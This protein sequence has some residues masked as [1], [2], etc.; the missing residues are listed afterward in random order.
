MTTDNFLLSDTHHDES[1]H[2]QVKSILLQ[3]MDVVT[4]DLTP[5]SAPAFT[6]GAIDD[7]LFISRLGMPPCAERKAQPASPHTATSGSEG[8]PT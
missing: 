3:L 4:L 8:A 7:H 2:C 6:M 5:P 1:T